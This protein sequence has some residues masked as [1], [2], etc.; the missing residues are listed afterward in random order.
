MPHLFVRLQVGCVIDMEY[1]VQTTIICLAFVGADWGNY[2]GAYSSIKTFYRIPD[3]I[4]YSY[5]LF[6]RI[7]FILIS[8]VMASTIAFRKDYDSIFGVLSF[9]MFLVA[10]FYPH[11]RTF[12]AAERYND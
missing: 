4:N 11:V 8:G 2:R 5:F 3:H 10:T 1:I 9:V 12:M 7:I 6:P